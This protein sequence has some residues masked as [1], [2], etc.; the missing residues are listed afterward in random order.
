LAGVSSRRSTESGTDSRP[1]RRFSLRFKLFL[2]IL[3]VALACILVSALLANVLSQRQIDRYVREVEPHMGGPQQPGPP[4][5]PPPPER[6]RN[7]NLIF[8]LAG[9]LA[10]LLAFILSFILADRI[11]KPLSDLTAAT[12]SIAEGDYGQR[13][14]VGGGREVE[15]LGK[16]FNTL[17]ENLERNEI[18]R[19][20]MVTDIAHEL[21]TPL[22]T[23][24]G[25]IEAL[26]DG[27]IEPDQATIDSL[28][29]DTLLLSRLVEDLQQLSLA[30]AGQL[31][32]DLMPVDV[33]ETVRAAVSRFEPKLSRKKIS[34]ELEI[35]P[36]LP[37][38]KADQLR[39]AQVL[40]N[41]VQNSLVHTPEGGSITVEA[42]RLRDEVV[43]SVSDTG[44]GI[45]REDLP[46]IFERFYRTDKS[47]TR[48]TGGTGLGLSIAKSLVEAHGGMIR[49]ESKGEKGT[50]IF[51]SVPVFR[52]D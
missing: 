14:D 23:L 20:S 17:S 30:E 8:I 52:R 10:I 22:T 31:K 15:E 16:A 49:A 2:A 5:Q 27:V 46:Y 29:E 43:F 32:L 44:P 41:L 3:C 26:E 4:H 25:H 51:F 36:D 40:N 9:V 21:R 12:E 37:K 50:A 47:R 48:A 33:G 1:K 18:L 42:K 24:R 35:P 34:L 7:I 38:V 45:S 19:R 28:M 13:V 39:I 6:P 11:S